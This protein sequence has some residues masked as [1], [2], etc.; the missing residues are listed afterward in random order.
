MGGTAV[1]IATGAGTV[2]VCLCRRVAPRTGAMTGTGA[3]T[4]GM[5]ATLT[6]VASRNLPL[7]ITGDSISLPGGVL[8]AGA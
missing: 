3:L 8:V 2:T 6:A 7:L 5:P 1:T 4:L